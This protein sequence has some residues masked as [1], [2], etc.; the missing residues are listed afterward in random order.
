LVNVSLRLVACKSLQTTL[1]WFQRARKRWLSFDWCSQALP[2]YKTQY[3][4]LWVLAS[5]CTRCFIGR[6]GPLF[7]HA[8]V[9]SNIEQSATRKTAAWR[10]V[11][12]FLTSSSTWPR[13]LLCWASKSATAPPP[14]SQGRC[15]LIDGRGTSLCQLPQKARRDPGFS[16][17]LPQLSHSHS[18]C[19]RRHGAGVLDTEIVG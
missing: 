10:N 4:G 5:V 12:L 18:H 13:Y 2:L 9:L 1:G 8:P 16:F 11:H 14:P 6:R 17:K 3:I 19:T 7:S 15:L